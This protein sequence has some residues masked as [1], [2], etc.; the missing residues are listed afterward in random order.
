MRTYCAAQIQCVPKSWVTHTNTLSTRRLLH[1]ISTHYYGFV[2]K[3]IVLALRHCIPFSH[4]FR[5]TT[6]Y[7]VEIFS[8]IYNVPF[9]PS[10]YCYAATLA[11]CSVEL[12]SKDISTYIFC[13]SYTFILLLINVSGIEQSIFIRFI[14][15]KTAGVCVFSAFMLLGE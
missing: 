13:L 15:Y 12:S 5:C 3:A 9:W 7:F 2:N 6:F 4:Y 11:H 8:A 14:N 1:I 10:S